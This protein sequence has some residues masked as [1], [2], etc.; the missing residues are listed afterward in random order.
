MSYDIHTLYQAWLSDPEPFELGYQ[1]TYSDFLK[2]HT[3]NY[4]NAIDDG[5]VPDPDCAW[6]MLN[7][8]SELP[9]D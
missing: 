4:N 1:R 3:G 2:Y 9:S 7:A 5:N 6:I 8:P